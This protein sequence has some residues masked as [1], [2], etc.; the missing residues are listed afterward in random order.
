LIDAVKRLAVQGLNHLIQSESWA[1][2]RLRMHAGA[3]FLVDSGPLKVSLA[4]DDNGLFHMTDAAA[5]PDVTLTLPADAVVKALFER[6]KLFSSVRLGG[7]VDVAESLAFVFRNLKWDAEADLARVVGDIAARRLALFGQA[8][9]K[10]LQDGLHKLAE[11]GKEY[12][13]EDSALLPPER[14]LA[15]FG[16]AVEQLRADVAGLEQRISRL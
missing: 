6:D 16:N 5:T 1:Q 8:L 11:N 12:I 7:V 9:A 13:V 14:D 4:I 3:K 15:A 2:E 10:G